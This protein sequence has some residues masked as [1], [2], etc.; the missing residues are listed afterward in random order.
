MKIG[1]VAQILLSI[2]HTC[3]YS[4]R[5][6]EIR[7]VMSSEYNH[8]CISMHITHDQSSM[9][10]LPRIHSFG[11]PFAAQYMQTYRHTHAH[12]AEDRCSLNA[13]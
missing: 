10:V 5:S 13:T 8:T 3:M 11:I 12:I 4:V 6:N 9:S 1:N 7:Y 2:F